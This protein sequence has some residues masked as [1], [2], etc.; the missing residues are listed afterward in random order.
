[1]KKIILNSIRFFLSVSIFTI[2][3]CSGY[4]KKDGKV[5]LRNSDEAHIGV[6][7]I[8][9]KK[10]DYKTFIEIENNTNLYLAKDKRYIYVDGSILIG[11]DPRTFKQIKEYY[12]KDKNYVYLL[13]YGN[14]VSKINSADISSFYLL[15]NNLWAKDKKSIFYGSEKLEFVN[16]DKF[17]VINENWGKDDKYFYWQNLKLESIDFKTAEILNLNFIK[18]KYN[19]F[20]H[21]EIVIGCD[22]STFRTDGIGYNGHDN[23]NMFDG[24]TNLGPITDEYRKMYIEE[25]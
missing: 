11:A 25:K 9:L 19:V 16:R 7:Y 1:M 14:E 4:T 6:K 20:F 8:E 22:A 17:I 3:G 13:G 15:D 5:F 23:K 18:D 2:F 21:N 24:T 10:A 12:W